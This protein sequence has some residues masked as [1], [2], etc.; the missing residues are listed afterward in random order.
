MT[1]RRAVFLDRD[2]VLNVAVHVDGKT[3]PP[4]D[5]DSLVIAPGV[6]EAVARLRAAGYLC[7]CVTNQPDVARGTRTR[8]NVD[9]MNEKVRTA[10]ALDDLYVCFHDNADNCACRKPKPGMLLSAAEKWDIALADSWMVGDRRTDVAA[11]RAAGCRTVLIAAA[12]DGASGADFVCGDLGG[13]A[14]V[15]VRDLP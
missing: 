1:G 2:G 13:A 7:I 15:I 10:L 12:D 6:G 8:D 3:Y 4:A 5:A 11:G 9:A 14:S